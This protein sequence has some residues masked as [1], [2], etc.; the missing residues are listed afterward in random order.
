[1]SFTNKTPNYELPQYVAED[2]PTY[3]GDFNEAMG[4][5]DTNMKNIDNKAISSVTTAENANSTAEEALSTANSAQSAVSQAT[6][7]ANQA[8]ETAENAQT[9]ATNAQSDASTAI[10]TANQANTTAGTAN[11]NA[12]TAKSTAESANSTATTAKNTADTINTNVNNWTSQNIGLNGAT[13]NLN[14][15]KYMNLLGLSGRISQGQ[16]STSGSTTTIGT[17]P[18]EFRPKATRTILGGATI[19]YADSVIARDVTINTNGSITVPVSNDFTNIVV[20]CMLAT[21]SW[22]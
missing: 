20:Q 8:K 18:S 1:M 4:K 3:L 17:L 9:T 12:N 16:G 6:T 5:I 21:K 14:A 19:I 10:T 13:L 2:K 7:T 15:N 11:T 22:F